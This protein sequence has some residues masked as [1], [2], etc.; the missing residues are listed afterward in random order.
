M[1]ITISVTNSEAA[2]KK[3]SVKKVFLDFFQDSHAK[4]LCQSLLFNKDP[5]L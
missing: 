5:A 2:A 4:Q 1:K 3:S